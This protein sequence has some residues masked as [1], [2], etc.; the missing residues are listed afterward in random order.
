MHPLSIPFAQRLAPA[1]PV[2]LR[3]V[4]G[5]VM[6]VHGWQKLTEMG[7][8]TF[9]A[10]M[11]AELGIPAPVLVGWL[12]TL[13]ELIGGSLLVIGLLTRISAAAV[14]VVLVGAAILVKPDL[15]LIAPM[16]SMLPGAELDLA[17]IA[18]AVGVLLLGPG[19]PSVDHAVGIESTV[20][21][22]RHADAP[23]GRD[24]VHA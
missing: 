5:T 15:G 14:T 22:L 13:V 18:G 12:I 3:L 16:G 11:V 19:K 23:A 24:A 21:E 8:A 7:P 1:A 9:G 17:L 6:A 2:V 20:P 10:G 4:V